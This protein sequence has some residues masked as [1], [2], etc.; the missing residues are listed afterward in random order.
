MK[1]FIN[2]KTIPIIVILSSLAGLALRLWTI[3]DGPDAFGLYPS[4]PLAWGL[5]W[6][7]TGLVAIAI[8]AANWK[9]KK[10]GS[11]E[12]NFPKSV[13]GMIGNV[14]AGISILVS[15][16]QLLIGMSQPSFMDMLLGLVGLGAGAVLIVL[17]VYRFQGKK[18]NFLLHGL[19]CL[20]FAL[21]LFICCR[22]WS[23][24]PQ[25]GVIVLPFL[26]S[27]V[28]MLACYQRTCFDVDLGNRRHSL[29]WSLLGTYLCILAIL[30]FED[31]HFYGACALW[32]MTDL[33]SLRP[34]KRKKLPTEE[35]AEETADETVEE[36]RTSCDPE[37]MTMEELENWMKNQDNQ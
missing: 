8:I 31:V 35:P 26:A 37:R 1:K 10:T 16:V 3:G 13:P 9:L 4:K 25:L 6:L 17:G 2:P 18:P 34:I 29:L 30:S 23:N 20:Y 5:L 28:L 22:T 11:Y 7:L 14:L 12:D 24:E 33:C 36:P 19:L 27:L 21:R 32:L 15:S